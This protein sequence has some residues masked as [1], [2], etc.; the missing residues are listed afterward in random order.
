MNCVVSDPILHHFGHPNEKV[1]PRWKHNAAR[2]CLSS[3]HGEVSLDVAFASVVILNFFILK[4]ECPYGFRWSLFQISIPW[5]IWCAQESP[6]A[7]W[8]WLLSG[9]WGSAASRLPHP[10]NCPSP[11]T[12]PSWWSSW[13]H[14]PPVPLWHSG[15]KKEQTQ[16]NFTPFCYFSHFKP[17]RESNDASK[18]LYQIIKF[19]SVVF[20]HGLNYINK[21]KP[22]I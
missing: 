16:V 12:V 20:S 2:Y 3:R 22:T 17:N 11:A 6:C 10:E 14:S 9:C 19:E 13:S 7:A 4:A 1:P 15:P 8:R 5:G 18:K 21:Q